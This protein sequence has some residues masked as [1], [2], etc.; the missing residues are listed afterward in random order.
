MDYLDFLEN[1]NSLLFL[2]K[3]DFLAVLNSGKLTFKKLT[4]DAAFRQKVLFILESIKRSLIL[5]LTEWEIVQRKVMFLC[6]RVPL[7]CITNFYRED[8]RYHDS[9]FPLPRREG[10]FLT[11]SKPPFFDQYGI[12]ERTKMQL[13]PSHF[14]FS[15]EVFV[16][17]DDFRDFIR[18]LFA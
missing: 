10:V 1:N 11:I 16:N 18:K 17:N 2:S 8:L 12:V 13:V 6:T 15:N 7:Y 9:L 5:S 14:Y 4:F 3:N